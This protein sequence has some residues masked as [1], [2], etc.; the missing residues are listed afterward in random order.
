MSIS[1]SDLIVQKPRGSVQ[2]AIAY[3]LT[4]SSKRSFTEAYIREL[5][6][7]CSLYNIDFAFAFAQF[8]DETACGTSAAWINE[9]NPAG[10]GIMD[11]GSRES[12]IY[13]SGEAAA[14]AQ[15]VHLY[16]Y[17]IGRIPTSAELYN[18]INLDPRYDNV[19][20][21]NWGGTVKRI[22]QFGNGKW[23]SNPT[24]ASQ[25]VD[26][27][28]AAF[29]N[30]SGQPSTGGTM[31]NKP[32][33]IQKYLHVSQDGYA[34]VNR[35]YQG[36][37]DHKIIVLHIQEGSSWG[38]WTW[39][40]Q[41]SASATIFAN[42]DGS[43]WQLVPETDGPW[44]NGDVCSPTSKGQSIMNA[45]GGDPNYYTLSIET[46]GYASSD[47]AMGWAAWPKPQAQLDAVVWQVMDWMSRY[48]IPI[49]RVI[50]HADINQCDRPGCPGD[51]FYNYVISAV[52]SSLGN[53]TTPT[54]PKPQYAKPV[55]VLDAEG[56]KWDGTKDLVVGK[57]TFRADKRSVKTQYR[58]NFRKYATRKAAE[59]RAPM[60]AEKGFS[61]L[62]WVNGEEIN[63]ERRWWIT[64]NYS[65]IH[66]SATHQKPNEPQLPLPEE[67]E[68]NTPQPEE[69]PDVVDGVT[70]I[71][72]RAYYS[73]EDLLSGKGPN[74]ED[75]IVPSQTLVIT[76]DVDARRSVSVKS[77]ARGSFK[78]GDEVKATHFVVGDEVDGESLW[79][80]LE[81]DDGSN[82]LRH[83]LRV[84]ASATNLRPS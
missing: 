32:T 1:A 18:Y 37:N 65:R 13:T 50:R 66:V 7:L 26:H 78:K 40:H 9:G 54:P 33:I 56:N 71:N 20:S 44:T 77:P 8:C 46:E 70:I 74:G 49:E 76:K 59:T 81:T 58:S 53:G 64:A 34:G 27:A 43:I 2:E 62:G 25:I 21:A 17:T 48:N 39:F 69:K 30:A 19:F 36:A 28:N 5:W 4:P 35:R 52:E 10:I 73:V 63:G 29:P 80:V 67:P 22:E 45:Y 31:P 42:R 68:D 82:P 75:V 16:A 41:V 57:A 84:P 72:G 55:P 15:M 24:Y 47:N 11:D 61:V 3:L 51:T 79:W 23:A 83:G 38:S 14:R 6:R 60:E 12:M